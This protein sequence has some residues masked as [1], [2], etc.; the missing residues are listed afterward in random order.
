MAAGPEVAAV[1]R[2]ENHIDQA[3]NA[4]TAHIDRRVQ[5]QEARGDLLHGDLGH[6]IDQT[7]RRQGRM[8]AYVVVVLAVIIAAVV[9]GV[10]L[11]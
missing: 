7:A 3:V 1:V 5:E 2:I 9:V 8:L 11:A 4:I 10:L 6:R